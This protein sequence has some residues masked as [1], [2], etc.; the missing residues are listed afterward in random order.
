M[1]KRDST[2][3][4]AELV[5]GLKDVRA[6]ILKLAESLDSDRQREIYL[7]TWSARELLAHLAGWD[8]T[9]IQAVEEVFSGEVPSFYEHADTDWVS[10]NDKL[11]C[12]FLKDNYFEMLSLVRETHLRLMETIEAIPADELWKDRGIRVKGWKVTIGRL[13]DAERQDE[14]EHYSQMRT[15]IEEGGKS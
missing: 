4:K 7:G 5:A 1:S 11:V 10:Y 3:R 8:D 9:N 2:T 13:L 14:E 6:R 15:F 12:E